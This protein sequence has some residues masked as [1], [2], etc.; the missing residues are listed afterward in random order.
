MRAAKGSRTRSV[1][2]QHNTLQRITARRNVV[3][4]G[5]TVPHVRSD[6]LK[7]P[8]RCLPDGTL[9]PRRPLPHVY[10]S[11]V[12]RSISRN[13]LGKWIL[14]AQLNGWP[15]RCSSWP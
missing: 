1:A 4:P 15:V 3:Q 10:K 13:E 2:A 6:G 12:E 5:A 8:K 9:K 7:D 14:C 11:D